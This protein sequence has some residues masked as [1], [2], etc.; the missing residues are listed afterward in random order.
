MAI[1]CS[2]R[3]I[4]SSLNSINDLNILKN[5]GSRVLLTPHPKEMSRLIDTSVDEILNN[6]IEICR[7]LSKEYKVITLLKGRNTIISDENGDIYI[8]S[9]GNDALAKAGSGDVLTGMIAGFS[10]YMDLMDATVLSVYLH[11]VCADLY[12]DSKSSISMMASEIVDYL[13]KAIFDFDAK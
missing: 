11:G 6:R 12:V 9:T 8:N 4:C 13:P 1:S 7:E 3:S 2:R 10:A 5:A